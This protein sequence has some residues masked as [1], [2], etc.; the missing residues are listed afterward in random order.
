LREVRPLHDAISSKRVHTAVNL[1]II[2]LVATVIFRNWIFSPE[3]PAGGDILGF[4]SREY[5]YG[6]NLRWLFVWRPNSLGYAEGIN[7]MDFFFMIVRFVAG[8]AVTT[9]KAFAFSSFILAGFSMYAFGYNYSKKNLAAMAGSLIYIL[10]PVYLSQLTEAHL[11]IMF[12]YALIPLIFL[13]LDKAFETGKTKLAIVAGV[14]VSIMVWGFLP[15]TAVIYGSFLL[16][17]VII[18][19]LPL[20]GFGLS[21]KNSKR[22]AKQILIIGLVVL[23]L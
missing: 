4:I 23:P 7:L 12:G 16:L 15:Q 19:F 18:K 9:A 21:S 20:H 1:T 10:N 13:F 3:W 11:D 2:F 8:N 14:L 5:L 22:Y 6:T 17:F